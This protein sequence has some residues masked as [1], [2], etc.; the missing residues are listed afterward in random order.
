MNKTFQNVPRRS[1]NIPDGYSGAGGDR[2]NAKVIV[3]MMML[4]LLSQSSL[5]SYGAI[6]DMPVQDN[7]M[8][9][10]FQLKSSAEARRDELLYLLEEDLPTDIMENLQHALQTMKEAEQV[11]DSDPRESSRLYLKALQGFRTTWELYLNYK[12]E[13][14]EQTF[15]EPPV[16][17]PPDDD[18]GDQTEEITQAK[19]VLLDRFKDRVSKKLASLQG[20]VDELEDEMSN[21]DSNTINNV[22]KNM[23]NKLTDIG[24]MIRTGSTD[25]ALDALSET[26]SELENG[27]S[28]LNDQQII[29]S[30]NAVSR[31]EDK[32]QKAEARND[33]TEN[34]KDKSDEEEDSTEF[35]GDSSEDSEDRGKPVTDEPNPSETNK[36][37]KEKDNQGKNDHPENNNN[38][39]GNGNSDTESAPNDE[40]EPETDDESPRNENAD[41]NNGND[42]SDKPTKDNNGKK[43]AH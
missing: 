43:K 35:V 37:K 12:P 23:R 15:S 39:V 14:P 7:E 3:C 33:S 2:L 18:E 4:V 17:D 10:L 42:N 20:H 11:F 31:F 6:D 40:P 36:D 9:V 32:I 25:S 5:V 16:E 22:L 41:S 8:A 24:K 29:N 28:G 26:S 30:I 19:G 21:D 13:A 1:F 34:K 38:G 27:I